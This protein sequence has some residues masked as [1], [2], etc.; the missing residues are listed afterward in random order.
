M[1][2]TLTLLA[3]HLCALSSS[4]GL[5]LEA[6]KFTVDSYT[7]KWRVRTGKQLCLLPLKPQAP[8]ASGAIPAL[9]HKPILIWQRRLRVVFPDVSV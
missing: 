7:P 9:L 6:S 8:K 5:G 4:A 1:P 3:R 2:A